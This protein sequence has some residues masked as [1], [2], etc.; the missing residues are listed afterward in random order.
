MIA[1]LPAYAAGFFAGPTNNVDSVYGWDE[2]AIT[3][4]VCD[5]GYM[6]P[7]CSQRVC[8]FGDDPMTVCEQGD[9]EQIQVI[10]VDIPTDGAAFGEAGSAYENAGCQNCAANNFAVQ[11]TT[12]DK[13]TFYTSA[14]NL[15]D[16]DRD[17]EDDSHLAEAVHT[18]AA[19][20]MESLPNFAARAVT[21]AKAANVANTGT[22]GSLKVT[23]LHEGSGNSF[24]KQNL[25]QC[26]HPR[27]V[28]TDPSGEALTTYG[29]AK[30]GCQP[31]IY[32]PRFVRTQV[33][34]DSAASFGTS[35]DVVFSDDS[36][37]TCPTGVT[38]TMAGKDFAG[39]VVVAVFGGHAWVATTGSTDLVAIGAGL[40]LTGA[41][42]NG[43]SQD[44]F[45]TGLAAVVAA[46]AGMT[47][48]KYYG[49]ITD[50]P[51]VTTGVHKVD[52][53]QMMM[54]TSIE[55]TAANVNDAEVFTLQYTPARCN[56]AEDKTVDITEASGLF[57]GTPLDNY[58]IENMECSGR[59]QCDRASGACKCFEGYTG[60][61]CG[62]QTILI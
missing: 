40:V 43:D 30:E 31:R 21:A 3:A 58:D 29:C 1:D 59:G 38:C 15:V 42:A 22:T 2:K 51:E 33:T 55:I 39:T 17:N 14:F 4:C 26:P 36:V 11:F 44:D 27:A 49:K 47:D 32:Q 16:F 23:F 57:T 5:G 50:H 62:D 18:A 9:T 54:D 19:D 41:A 37:L 8:P 46:N 25:M 12:Y 28:G 24:G 56:A 53:S 6:G 35:S 60:L 61:A 7:D 13:K 52:I 48:F 34:D 10:T 45:N 20:A